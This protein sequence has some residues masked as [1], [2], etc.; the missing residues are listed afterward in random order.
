MTYA[1]NVVLRDAG[2]GKK[3]INEKP[4]GMAT[5]DRNTRRLYRSQTCA[6]SG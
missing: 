6:V 5:Q 4:M 3:R 2:I 1:L